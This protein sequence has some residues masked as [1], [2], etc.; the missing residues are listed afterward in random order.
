MG[1][2]HVGGVGPDIGH[3]PR[4][5]GGD[6]EDHGD[7]GGEDYGDCDGEDYDDCGGEDYDH[8]ENHG[9]IED[10]GHDGQST[11]VMDRVNRRWSS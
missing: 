3:R 6:T 2:D 5:G 11:E 4:E 10:C 1:G 7:S 8:F 9:Y